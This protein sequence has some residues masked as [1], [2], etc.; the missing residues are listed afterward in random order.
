MSLIL[1]GLPGSGKT[2]VGQLLAQKLSYP[3]VD[4]D[5]LIEK[6]FSLPDKK[7]S[8]REITKRVG[9]SQF[10]AY[11]H[12][13]IA[14]LQCTPSVVATGGG[15]LLQKE[16]VAILHA[17][18]TLIYLR[19]SPQFLLPRVVRTGVPTYL[20]AE[21]LLPSFDRL[22]SERIPIFEASTHFTVDVEDFLPE[23]I[24]Q[25]ILELNF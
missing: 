9:I 13:I 4:T 19:A 8:C 24:L 14:N 23:E 12:H 10:R 25:N 18:G 15:S 6:E 20:D 21:N 3:F 1:C 5:R 2:T 22:A 7:E 17:M 16:N 11:E